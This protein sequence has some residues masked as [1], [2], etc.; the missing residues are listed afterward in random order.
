VHLI[1]RFSSAL[2]M[3][4]VL[5]AGSTAVSSAAASPGD[6]HVYVNDNTADVNTVAGFT[7]HGDGTLTPL[8]GSPFA[9]GGAGKGALIGSQG[10]LQATDDGRYLLVA[11]AGSSEISVLRVLPAG[12]LLQAQGSPVSS[13]G[14]TPI[15][16]AVHGR[17]VY[18]A[19]AGSGGSGSNYSGFTINA[20]GHLAPIPGSTVSLPATA[21]PGDILFNSTGTNLVGIEVGTTDPSTFRIDSFA[22]GS[23]GRL[24]AAP[25]SPFAAEAAGPFGSEFSPT[26]PSRLYVSNAHGG[27]GNGSVSAFSVATGGSLTSIGGSPYA[28]IQTAPCWVEITHDGRWLFA[29]NTGST[30]ISSYAIQADGSLH[31]LGSTGFSSGTGIR[32]FDARLDPSGSTLYVVDAALNAVSAF[33][34]SGGALSEVTSS[35]FQLPAGATPFG[36]VAI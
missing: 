1:R 6:T 13:G 15:S 18:V 16:I 27:A 11:D 23:D 28:D 32:P 30:T 24:T 5:I 26:N 4:C 3:A 22:V 21:N 7:R 36:I 29:I 10:A 12:S 34:V 2:A 35:P 14:S 20:G 19:N 33:S 25:G 9:A 8:P 31:L 17:L